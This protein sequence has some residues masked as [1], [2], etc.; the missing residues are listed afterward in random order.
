MKAEALAEPD[1]ERRKVLLQQ[2]RGNLDTLTDLRRPPEES[3][4][5]IEEID[6]VEVTQKSSPFF[7]RK[8]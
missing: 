3:R 6:A 1:Y 7:G 2:L 5:A 4:A 8:G